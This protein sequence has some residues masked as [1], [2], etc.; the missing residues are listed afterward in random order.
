MAT[1]RNPVVVTAID[2]EGCWV[3]A[4]WNGNTPR[5]YRRS[6][7]LRWRVSQPQPKRTV[8]GMPDY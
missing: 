8:M 6:A 2:P 5:K 4:S 3:E 7:V 1:T